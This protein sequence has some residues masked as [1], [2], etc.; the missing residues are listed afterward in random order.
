MSGSEGR[1]PVDDYKAINNE[2]KN[3]S[4][5]VYKKPQIIAA[6]KMDLESAGLN[7]TRFKK[8]IKV[9]IYPISALK[10]QGLE[11]LIEAVS[12]KL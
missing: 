10:K 1:D 9:R 2:L 4:Q 8:L 6:N 11:D 12:K 5:E 7:L 3:Y